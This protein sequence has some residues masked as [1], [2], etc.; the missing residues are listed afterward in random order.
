MRMDPPLYNNVPYDPL[1]VQQRRPM[2]TTGLPSPGIGHRTSTTQPYRAE[3]KSP[4][5]SKRLD[6]VMLQYQ[7][8]QQQQKLLQHQQQQYSHQPPVMIPQSTPQDHAY[9]PNHHGYAGTG[10][11]R[12]LVRDNQA[13]G[14]CG[15]LRQQH[16]GTVFL[17]EI[18]HSPPL[19]GSSSNRM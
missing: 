5:T 10:G 19:A 9:L 6:D 3:S 15:R 2:V 11:G 7:Q 12:M 13:S 8:Q 18:I 17:N 14:K 4:D 1:P 16:I